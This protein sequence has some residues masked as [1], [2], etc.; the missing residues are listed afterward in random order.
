[1]TKAIRVLA[2]DDDPMFLMSLE[3]ELKKSSYTVTTATNGAEALKRLEA[4]KFDFIISDISMP[5]L[6]GIEM[7]KELKSRMREV[8]VIMF[9]TG[10][11]DLSSEEARRMGIDG[12][13]SKTSS[14]KSLMLGIKNF[15][16]NKTSEFTP[17]AKVDLTFS[18][19]PSPIE[20]NLLLVNEKG[21]F[22]SLNHEVPQVYDECNF[23]IDLPGNTSAEGAGVVNW[24]RTHA[25]E[26][27]PAACGVEF[28]RFNGEGQELIQQLLDNTKAG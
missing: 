8:P 3:R 14:R 24:V 18:S 4:D 25:S 23:K 11:A 20:E 9:L 19:M 27:M 26:S 10:F 16:S 1:M 28:L 7:V 21:F 5:E 22:V 6:D 12:L 2:V 17:K 13:F 15:I